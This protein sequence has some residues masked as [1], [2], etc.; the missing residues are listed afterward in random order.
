MPNHLRVFERDEF[1]KLVTDSG[2]QIEKQIYKGFFWSVWWAL[3]WV[4]GQELGDADGPIL[5]SWAK[6][7]N[8]LL[9]SGQAERVKETMDFLMPKSQVILARKPE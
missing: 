3:F 5:S 4:S 8:E 2:L 1:S 7:W 9:K 6:T